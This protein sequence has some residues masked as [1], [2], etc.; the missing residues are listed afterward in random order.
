MR[1]L[2]GSNKKNR[3]LCGLVIQ[4]YSSRI[5]LFSNPDNIFQS[6]LRAAQNVGQYAHGACSLC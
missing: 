3:H 4:E 2:G 6:N 5:L 1:N